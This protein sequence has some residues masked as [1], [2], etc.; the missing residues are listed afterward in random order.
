MPYRP[1]V[2]RVAASNTP[3]NPG[4]LGSA[5]PNPMIPCSRNAPTA[6]TGSPNARKHTANAAAFTSHSTTDQ[7]TTAAKRPGFL[8]TSSPATSPSAIRV[9]RS[10]RRAGRTACV[11]RPSSASQ[12]AGRCTT[13]TATT[14]TTPKK[15]AAVVVIAETDVRPMSAWWGNADG[16]DREREGRE[17]DGR[18]NE[19]A[20]RPAHA[21]HQIAGID[22]VQRPRQEPERDPESHDPRPAR[23]GGAVRSERN[24]DWVR[25]RGQRGRRLRR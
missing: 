17:R 10:A 19:P 23:G 5:T 12:G 14:S 20:V 18:E 1:S 13:S 3:T 25:G 9:I 4:E 6:G 21:V 2:A 22:A 15:A 16:A 8:S 11:A 7:K 24:R